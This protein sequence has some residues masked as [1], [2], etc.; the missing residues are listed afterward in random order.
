METKIFGTYKDLPEAACN[1]V[2][3]IGNFDGVHI[4]H[5][6]LLNTARKIADGLDKSLAVL[7]FEPHPRRLFRPDDPPFRLTTADLKA[8]RLQKAKVDYIFAIPFDW[9][10]ASLPAD[11]FIDQVLRKEL[12]AAHIVIGYDF[13]FGQLRKGTPETLKASGIAVTIVDKVA[14]EGD[15]A[16]SSS[17]IRQA[18]RLG[19]IDR[20]NDI[21]GWPWEMRGVVQKGDQR[22]RQLGYPTANV[23]LGDILHPSYGVYATFVKI[24]EDGPDSPWLP[25]ATNI[26]IRPMFAVPVGQVETYIFD[27]N[28]DIYSKTLCIRPVRRLRGEA[29]FES[30]DALISQ[31]TQDCAEARKILIPASA[32]GDNQR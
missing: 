28:R 7:T 14:D 23:P 9:D 3:V 1:A 17:A 24:L 18:L 30:L 19:D 6:A 21:L 5:Q 25:S 31:I 29:K 26:G 11:Q 16:L 8:E 15:D 27:F 4:G 20:A 2:V 13:C 22:G 32:L 10:F 12:K